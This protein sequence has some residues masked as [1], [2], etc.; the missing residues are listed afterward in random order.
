MEDNGEDCPWQLVVHLHREHISHIRVFLD[1][2]VSVCFWTAVYLEPVKL[3][4]QAALMQRLLELHLDPRQEVPP[5]LAGKWLTH[6][7][8]GSA[9]V[10]LAT[11]DS[12]HCD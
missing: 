8:G 9:E 3:G 4:S 12:P 5:H 2:C 1:R 11:S 6:H 7:H 10:H